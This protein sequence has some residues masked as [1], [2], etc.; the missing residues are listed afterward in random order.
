ML[1]TTLLSFIDEF[2]AL[3]F[4]IVAGNTFLILLKLCFE[5]FLMNIPFLPERF[6][7][8]TRF[9]YPLQLGAVVP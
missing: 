4:D 8:D 2:R 6:D 9:P 3:H 5:P 7:Y 1:H